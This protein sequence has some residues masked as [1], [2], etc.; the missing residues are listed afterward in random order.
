[1]SASDQINNTV[2]ET[3]NESQQNV[4][5]PSALQVIFSAIATLGLWAIALF[6]LLISLIESF[7]ADGNLDLGTT[8]LMSAAGFAFLG[9]SALLSAGFA[10]LRIIGKTIED[11]PSLRKLG[12]ALRPPVL[13]L[14]F[15]IIWAAG[16]WA[17]RDLRFSFVVLPPLNLLAVSLP[18]L[19]IVW[20]GARKLPSGSW[21][22]KWGLFATGSILSPMI[23]LVLEGFV[24]I[25][26]AVL[27][28]VMNPDLLLELERM[29]VGRAIG[30]EESEMLSRIVSKF[31]VQ[32]EILMIVLA[33]FSVAVPLI[34]ELFKTLGVWFLA[35]RNLKPVEGFT[36]GMISGAGFALVETLLSSSA[37]Q[38]WGLFVLVRIGTSL[39]HIFT[40][41]LIGWG[42]VL[43]WTEKRYL[44]LAG[45]YL[46]AVV[47]HGIWNA[48]TVLMGVALLP[49]NPEGG[50]VLPIYFIIIGPIFLL[51]TSLATF[52]YL[53]YSNRRLSASQ[54]MPSDAIP[55]AVEQI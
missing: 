50:L 8:T 15:P 36:A 21:Q 22:R 49:P 24:M 25:F 37:P 27:A 52:I 19:W 13:I 16:A 33:L 20:V 30:V 43:A 12:R 4:H 45:A 55:E 38:D 46:L 23:I 35:G 14:L 31:I 39:V 28:L 9:L 1:M 44:H 47:F 34:E 26:F 17:A 48:V 6:F 54:D 41:G 32:P 29:S 3:A 42:L 18:I 10:L 2:S 51:F 40:G 53:V 7:G 5:W 11:F